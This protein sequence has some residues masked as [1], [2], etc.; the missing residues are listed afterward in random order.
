MLVAMLAATSATAQTTQTTKRPLTHRDFDAWRSINTPVLSRDGKWLAYSLQPQQGDGELVIRELSTG[1]EQRQP[2]GALPPPP[3]T[4]NEENPD[5]PPLPRAIRVA[6]SSD[7][8]FVVAT[9]HPSQ[10]DVAAAR[11][12]RKRA[13]E[14]PKGGLLVVNV[15]SLEATH[16]PNVKNMQVPSRGGAWLAYLK[17]EAKPE[18]AKTEA[19]TKADS[20]A[21][22]D[23]DQAATRRAPP[24]SPAGGAA[25]V[26]LG[27]ELVVRDL[28]TGAERVYPNVSEY[29]FARDGKTL[30]YSVSSKTETDNG[31][32]AVTPQAATAPVAL[33]TGKGK[34]LKLTWDREQSQTAFVSDRDAAASPAADKT[35]ATF[36]LYHWLRGA[37]GAKEVVSATT[38]GF[39][40]GMSVSDKGVVGFSRD[41]KKLHVAAAPAPKAPRAADD[42]PIDEQKVL[43]DLWRWNDDQVQSIQKVRAVQ[44]RNRSYR[45]VLD[46][47]SLRYQQLAD[48]SL[49]NVSVSD[50][51]LAAL[52]S[53]DRAYRR[54]TDYDGGYTDLY[55]INPATGARKLAVRKQRDSGNFSQAQQNLWSP[56][57]RH[58]LMYQNKHWH[59][60][61]SAD[62]TLRNL[63][64]RIKAAFH[65][66]LHDSPSPAPA[67]GTAGWT[68]DSS[69][70]LV[71]DRFDVW[72]LFADG[73]AA[74]NLTRGAGRLEKTRLR[75]QNTEPQD[76]DDDARGID[77]K[78]PL[79][80]RGENET[81][82][83]SG[84]FR[85]NW[86]AAALPQR[87]VWGDKNFRYVGRAQEAEVLLLT[88]SRFDAFP[89]LQT[90]GNN[91]RNIKTVSNVGQQ[92]QAFAW[93]TGELMAFTSAKG[94][95]L[96]AGVY[97]P[98]NFD[99]RKKYPL[100]VYIY[101]RLSQDVH[102]FVN[103]APG[104]S[105][106]RALYVSN[107][108]V[109]LTPDIAYTTGAPGQSALDAV[110]PAI[111]KLVKQGFIDEKSIGIQGHSWGGFQI[112]WMVTKTKRFAAVGAGAPVGNMTSA[113]SGIRWGSGLPRQF[114]YEQ[115]QS[116]IGKNL[117]AA[118]AL[119]L[120]NS[121]VFHINSVTTPMLILAN[122]ADDAVP[123]YQGIELFLA[124]RRHDK[125]AYLFNYNGQLHNL[126]RRAD[127]KDFALRMQQFFDH[128]LKKSPKPEWM[129]KGIAFNDREDEKLRFGKTHFGVSDSK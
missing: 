100:M 128:F 129:E 80:M 57:G 113:Y 23:S 49:R 102:N 20:L 101:E 48:E 95:P 78:K 99:A 40:V 1:K 41:G 30:L 71:Y 126:R 123:W 6:F 122:D 109:V 43:A 83:A 94:V 14:M 54:L 118:P 116:R 121:P 66:E 92:M 58:V 22:D 124:L 107:G 87:L 98:E 37:A 27:T 90:S 108:Y 88:A 47:A 21:D 13:D 84:F 42:T 19:P 77:S 2:V 89:E 35:P 53:D 68:R 28:A 31:L 74:V 117:Q 16:I 91:F 65:N 69:A 55:V 59:L 127:Q 104:N 39:P 81:T 15:S 36:K 67:Y 76:E 119:Y 105:I 4:P 9:T 79:V 72:Q 114:Q 56:D 111:D 97:K 38:P 5:A 110:M 64:A 52:G 51:G 26:T 29:W 32:Y 96:Q 45:G 93:G 12:A 10:A 18:P 85:S 46:L 106:N 61:N 120:A 115:A 17:E 7:S 25:T 3:T 44:E 24:A 75:I 33:L 60:L 125:E 63:T 82:R 34:Y 70:V 8:R 112:A 73:R 103:P 62:G 86:D 11:K 50:D